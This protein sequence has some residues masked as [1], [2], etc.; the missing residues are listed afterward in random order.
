MKRLL[1]MGAFMISA[2]CACNRTNSIL[3]QTPKAKPRSNKAILDW[4]EMAYTSMGGAAYQ[5]SLLASRVKAMMHIAMHDAPNAVIPEFRT[6]ALT[7]MDSKADPVAAAAHAAHSV[8]L[9]AFPER[10][11]SLD[12]MLKIS[13]ASITDLDALDRGKQLGG[14]AA[15]AILTLRANDG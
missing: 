15:T 14:E 6:Y 7:K 10:K 12:S 9:A 11:S 13:T 1:V 2:F 8:L 3:A 4:N 5:H